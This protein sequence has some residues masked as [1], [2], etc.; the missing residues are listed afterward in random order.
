M[1][2]HDESKL[3]V[4]GISR[5]TSQDTLRNHFGKYGAVV[6]SVIARDRTTGSHRGFGFV[7]FSDSSAVERALQDSHV[8]LER[9]VEVKKAIPRNEQHQNQQQNKGLNRNI[10]SSSGGSAG[11]F[12][13]KKIFVGGL[14]PILTEEEF[15][16]YFE[17]FGRIT[18]VVVMYDNVTSRPR[19]FGFITFDSE[20]AVE[21]VM[22]KSFHELTGKLVEVKRAV[23]KEGSN[24]NGNN[25]YNSR[26]GGGRENYNNHQVVSYPLYYLRNSVF[27]GFGSL[28]GY[29][30]SAGY[31]YGVGPF[32]GVFPN[33]GYSGIAYGVTPPT[34][35]SPWN[36]P[37]MFGIR[38]S[39]YHCGNF[40]TG[41]PNYLNGGIGVMGMETNGYNGI[42]GGGVNG[43]LN[44]LGNNN[45]QVST[46]VTP[47]PINE[48][49]EEDN[50]G[51]LRPSLVKSS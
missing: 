9:T 35:G 51:R 39:P 29:G 37:A 33:G 32:G 5:E 34:P 36:S 8:I 1:A 27:P 17:T 3:F 42:A 43:E 49:N 6:D 31:P 24:N 22:K 4:G 50:S 14:A 48:G 30:G 11:Q 13:T 28:P 38:G 47:A 18:D 20:D 16:S 2:D 41:Y 23:P 44:Q 45:S 25:G 19:G 40:A 15:K 26:V 10:G 7:S 21:E 12:R 46:N